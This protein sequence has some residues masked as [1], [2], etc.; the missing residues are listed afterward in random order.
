[1]CSP[2]AVLPLATPKRLA[3]TKAGGGGDRVGGS[4]VGLSLQG[5]RLRLVAWTYYTDCHKLNRALTAK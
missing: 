5:V 4:A 1:V 2:P 3:A